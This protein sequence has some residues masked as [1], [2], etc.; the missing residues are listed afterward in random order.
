MLLDILKTHWLFSVLDAEQVKAVSHKFCL[1]T[2]SKGQS[3]FHEFDTPEYLYVILQGEVSIETHTIDGKVIKIAHL[4][5]EDV[6]GEFALI[7]N[8]ARSAG[9]V[10]T[11]STE[12]AL[13]SRKTFQELVHDNPQFSQRLLVTLVERL[14][15]SNNQVEAL[16][17]QS[18]LQ[19]TARLLL[20]IQLKGSDT[21][22]ITQSQLSD[23]LFASREK[24]NTKLKLLEKLQAIETHRGS[25][26]IID[27]EV[28]ESLGNQNV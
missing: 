5:D 15:K 12:L 10:A 19:R 11:K 16:V 6:F 7:D 3:V 20:D 22:K 14:R 2:Y 21:L 4:D 8:G 23:R 25:I 9:A 28:L 17:S 13:L 27:S 1:K 18:L 26:E 24:V